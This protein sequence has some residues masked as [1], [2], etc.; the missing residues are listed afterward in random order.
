[1]KKNIIYII[2]LIV[3][4]LVA[5]YLLTTRTKTSTIADRKMD[6]SFTV[7]DTSAIDKIVIKDKTPLEVTLTRNEDYWLVD[8]KYRARHEAIHTLL[9]TLS[10]MKLRNFLPERTKPVV[11][12][13]LT[14]FGKQVDIYKNGKLFKT[15]YVGTDTPDDMGTYMMIKGSDAPYAVYIPGFNGYLSSRF[16]ADPMLW[17]SRDIIRIAPVNLKEVTMVYPDSMDAS[18]DIKI[19]SADSFYVAHINSDQ[20]IKNM[21]RVKTIAYL[22][23]FRRLSYEAA[24]P[25][26]DTLYSQ[27]DSLLHSQPVF[28][29]T[30][31]DQ[32]N[33]KTHVQ[34]YHLRKYRPAD[35][36]AKG[37]PKY[38]SDRLHGIINGEQM[39]LLQYY[40][41]RN[42]LKPISYFKVY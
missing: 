29:L 41:L 12:K 28:D 10:K 17:R 30:L 19:F 18:F 5:A 15:I 1:M 16:F 20:P 23:N 25:Q 33:N 22:N 4:V 7:P 9:Y 36:P 2:I 38:D 8:G 40:G 34:G 24:I 37:Y 11:I 13:R 26:S 21:A 3:L 42:V 35:I 14:V 39:V 32:D 31:I 27:K 6:Y